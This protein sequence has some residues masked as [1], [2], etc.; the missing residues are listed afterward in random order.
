MI[1]V[2]EHGELDLEWRD[3][4]LYRTPAADLA[5]EEPVWKVEAVTLDDDEA[6]PVAQFETEDEARDFLET[7]RDDLRDMTASRF[8][9]RYG[10][11]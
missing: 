8:A 1:R 7:I 10:L 2:D 5:T 4:V 6:H 3:D 11:S 9:E